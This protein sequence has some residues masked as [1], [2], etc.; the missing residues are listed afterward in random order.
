MKCDRRKFVL[1]STGMA[2]AASVGT[3]THASAQDANVLFVYADTVLSGKNIPA[4]QASEKDCV[5]NNRFPRNS[6]VVW[7]ARVMDPKTGTT[8]D[9]TGLAK[10]EVKLGDGQV[11]AMK[12]GGHPSK[13][14]KDFYWTAAWLVPKDY[15]T[16]TVAY[17]I[18]ATA[19]DGRTGEYKPFDVATSLLTITDVVM[20]DIAAAGTTPATPASTPAT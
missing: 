6:Q 20:E 7:R 5:L 18:T 3:I 8:M 1:V 11:F 17:S 13:Q 9:D 12:Y 15:P 16:G 14:P 2:V 19:K 10:L 4:D